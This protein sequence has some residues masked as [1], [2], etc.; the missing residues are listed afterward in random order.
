[1]SYKI[2]AVAIDASTFSIDRLYDY[3]IP[4]ELYERAQIG[5]RVLVPFGKGN[6]RIEGIILSFREKSE[7]NLL[8]MIDDVLDIE[9]ILNA[10]QI[11]LAI[12]LRERLACTF[13]DCIHAMLPS[14]VWFKRNDTYTLLNDNIE[15]F[16]KTEY[17]NILSCFLENKSLTLEQIRK[18]M[19]NKSILIKLDALCKQGILHYESKIKKNVNDKKVKLY[20]LIC[21]YNEAVNRES[22]RNTKSR[23]IKLDIISC[24]ADGQKL[25]K[26]E[27][28]YLTGA[29]SNIL[30]GLVKREIIECIKEERFRTQKYDNIEILKEN[31]L[32]EE[33]ETVYNSIKKVYEQ[34]DNKTCLLHGITGSGKTEVY[35]K[36]TDYMIKNEKSVIILVPEIGLTPQFINIF[37]ARFGNNVAILHSAL[38]VG[39]RYDSWKKIKMGLCK[40]VLGTRSAVFAPLDFLG[41][42]IIDEEHDNAYQSENSPR[43]HAR[44]VAHYR[45]FQ[46]KALLLLGSATPS[47]ES[48]YKAINKEYNLFEL[49]ERYG[50]SVI[51]NVIIAD[52]RGTAR[53]GFSG[54]IGKILEEQIRINLEKEEQTIL[55]LNRRGDSRIVRCAICGW[56]PECFSC[57]TAMTYH[58][59]NSRAICHYCGFSRKISKKCPACGSEHLVFEMAGTQKVE[60]EIKKIFKDV[61]IVRMDADTTTTKKSYEQIFEKFKNNEAEIL[62]GTQ[63]VTKGL[64]FDNVTLVGVIEADQSLYSQDYRAQ[65]RTFSL[66]TQVIGR[67]GRRFKNGRAVI[68]TYSP[69]HKV[70]LN[71]ARQDYISFYNYEI[72]RRKLMLC[73]PVSQI[74]FICGSGEIETDVIDS[75]VRLK[76][77]LVSLM[78]GQFSD[79]LFTVLGPCSACVVKV[80]GKYRYHLTMRCDDGKRRRQLVNGVLREFSNDRLNKGVSLHIEL[81]PYTI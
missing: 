64:D 71:A 22:R 42:I 27:L 52:M 2:C 3:K 40:I 68:Q 23:N 80:A 55:F 17:Y 31:K 33:Q 72:E 69:E 34:N 4:H 54:S 35:L 62:I 30:S 11:K 65:E 47:I 10:Q 6:K 39:E 66:I 19:G 41:A 14:G 1:M 81:N 7:Y 67:A 21:D 46:S 15:Q 38:S 18:M 63:M 25:S 45:A 44:D 53:K 58:S 43:Y 59:V 70:I 37:T 51:P 79:F 74:L 75:L 36:I 76:N 56:T 73:P 13:Y 57:S 20:R 29:T 16:E 48:Y 61:K 8:K 26:S 28:E 5:S 24:L 12:W 9:P 60:Q 78:Q 49:K 77:R 50:G 32:S